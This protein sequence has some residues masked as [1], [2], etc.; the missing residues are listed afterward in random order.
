MPAQHICPVLTD[1][2]E[3]P[4]TE[5]APGQT[6]H[7]FP[8]RTPAAQVTA[9]TCPTWAVHIL[10]PFNLGSLPQILFFCSYTALLSLAYMFLARLNTSPLPEHLP[11]SE[12][13]PGT[14][15]PSRLLFPLSSLLARPVAGGGPGRPRSRRG[16]PLPKVT[17]SPA[18]G[19]ASPAGGARSPPAC[20]LT[21][22]LP[23]GRR[24][25]AA[26]PRAGH[27]RRDRAGPCPA[28]A[29]WFAL[30]RRGANRRDAGAGES[31]RGQSTAGPAG[32]CGP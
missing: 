25:R 12:L 1:P 13:S 8:Q 32:R 19:P 14:A 29:C 28:T 31:G 5:E 27:S 24:V 11:R 6:D 2:P 23:A 17:A 30:C 9:Q 15:F 22:R 20:L 21:Q 10:L 18:H 26:L 16:S 4:V 3:R 7:C